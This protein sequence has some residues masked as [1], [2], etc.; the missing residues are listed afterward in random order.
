MITTFKNINVVYRT[1]FKRVL[2]YY[3]CYIVQD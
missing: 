3:Q 2:N 1:V